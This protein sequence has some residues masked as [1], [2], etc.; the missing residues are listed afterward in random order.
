VARERKRR[1]LKIPPVLFEKTQKIVKA[2][3]AE[4]GGTFLSYWNSTGGSVCQNDVLGFYEV[5]Q[6]IGPQQGLHLF[7]KSD[8]GD[9]TASLRIVNLLRRYARRV[10]VLLPLECASAATMVALGADEIHMGPLAFLT[11]VDTSITHDLSPTDVHNRR[12]SVS[13]DELNRA[14]KLW[15]EEVKRVDGSSKTDQPNP[16]SALFQFVHPLVIGAVDRSSSLSVKLC[17]EILGFHMK[18]PGRAERI[19]VEL[20]SAYPAHDYPIVRREAARLGLEVKDLDPKLNEMLLDLHALYSEMGQQAVTDYDE[21][22]YHNNEILN[23]L[24]TVGI[25]VYY[26]N[27]KD[28]HYRTEEKR[29]VSMNDNSSWRKIEKVGSKTVRSVFHIR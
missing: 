8:G 4:T 21:R 16:Y 9:G 12:V 28:W 13:Q 15:H 17:S 7:L 18:D 23:I 6:R 5:L 14:V 26:Q 20:N 1:K 2:V 3:A 27:D 25:Q 29:W 22:N 24:E 11:A 19:S 10:A